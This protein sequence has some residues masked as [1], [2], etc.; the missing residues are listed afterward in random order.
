MP[1]L[2]RIAVVRAALVLALLQELPLSISLQ[3]DQADA[4]R[5]KP[6]S[7]QT[8]FRFDTFNDEQLWT[9][10]LRMH[11][12]IPSVN[13]VTALAVG[14]KVD[15]DALPPALLAAL[16]AGQVD[17][18]DPAVTIEL[19]RLNAVVGLIGKVDD[20]VNSPASVP[21]CAL[22]LHR[23]QLIH[24][25]HWETARRMAEPRTQCRCDSRPVT[26]ARSWAQG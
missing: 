5:G 2:T 1:G 15:V 14:L 3:A 19:L 23:R 24:D 10:V 6:V 20:A 16:Q 17:L 12:A 26:R 25:W 9:N 22:P 7:G 18:T 8:I 4:G 21:L 13:P 11:E